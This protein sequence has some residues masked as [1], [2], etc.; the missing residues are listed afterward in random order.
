MA[1]SYRRTYVK[2]RAR[3]YSVVASPEWAHSVHVEVQGLQPERWYWYQFDV[4]TDISRITSPIG[5]T[6]TAPSAASQPDRFSFAFVSC[7]KYEA[8]LYTAIDHLCEEDISL[9]IHLSDYI[10]EKGP[11]KGVRDMP[12]TTSVSLESYRNRYAY[13][14]MDP[15]LKCL[16]AQFP[17]AAVSDDHEVANNYAGLVPEKASQVPGFQQRRAAAYRAYYEHMPFRMTV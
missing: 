2:D 12:V 6:K 4:G 13:Y 17:F 14:K 10:Y 3:R 8:G 9:L 16:H 5:R 15:S 7:Q 11:I 1:R